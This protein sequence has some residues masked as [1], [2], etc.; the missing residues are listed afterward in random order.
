LILETIDE[1]STLQPLVL[2]QVQRLGATNVV[3]LTWTNTGTLFLL[4]NTEAWPDGWS[5][6][7]NLWRTN[8]NW[9]STQITNTSPAQFFRLRGL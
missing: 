7:T 3:S 5:T 4:E 2:N 6:V 1:I 8:G 9:V